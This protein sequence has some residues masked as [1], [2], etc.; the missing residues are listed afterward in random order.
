LSLDFVVKK[1]IEINNFNVVFLILALPQLF[2][3]KIKPDISEKI[4]ELKMYFKFL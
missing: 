1:K 4:N 2:K 3:F